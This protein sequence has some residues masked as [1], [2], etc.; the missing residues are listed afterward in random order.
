MYIYFIFG[1]Y[2]LSAYL[3]WNAVVVMISTWLSLAAPLSGRQPPVSLVMVCAMMV[4]FFILSWLRYQLLVDFPV[5]NPYSS[6][7]H[8]WNRVN[9]MIALVPVKIIKHKK[10][11][12]QATTKI[13]KAHDD[14]IKWKHFPRNWPFVR[15]IHRGPVNSPHKGQWRGA[16]MFSFICVWINNWVNNREADDLRR[17]SAHYDVIVMACAF[18]S[19]FYSAVTWLLIH[20]GWDKIVNIFQ[21]TF[22]NP[23][24][25]YWIKGF[26]ITTNLTV[27]STKYSVQQQKP[28]MI[29]TTAPLWGKSTND[30]LVTRILFCIIWNPMSILERKDTRKNISIYTSESILT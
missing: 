3:H 12:R 25:P 20:W 23:F 18:S 16:L 26:Q 21:M 6:R 13:D 1:I 19:G 5:C 7:L 2:I 29:L 9:C 4:L 17:Y 30:L 10:Y 15:G 24:R 14:V 11:V 28:Q 8:Q 22:S 27:S